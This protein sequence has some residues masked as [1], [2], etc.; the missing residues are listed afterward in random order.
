MNLQNTPQN[1]KKKRNKAEKE[2]KKERRKKETYIK[3]KEQ[4]QMGRKEELK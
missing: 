3:E 1:I 4:E 2:L